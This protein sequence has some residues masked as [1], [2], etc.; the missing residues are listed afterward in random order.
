MIAVKEDLTR[1]IPQREPMMM[2]D[3]LVEADDDHAVTRFRILPDNVF[4][5]EGKFREP[6]LIENIAQTAAAQAGY[7]FIKN[8]LPVPIGYI[9]K[10]NNLAIAELPLVGSEI[11]TTIRITNNVLDITII[12]G[13]VIWHDRLICQCEMSIFVKK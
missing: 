5:A 13:E 12:S 11:N 4:V 10:I 2:I 1:Y 8:S 3:R 6:G 9:A 7:L